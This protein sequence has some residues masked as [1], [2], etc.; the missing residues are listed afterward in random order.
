MLLRADA[1]RRCRKV[2]GEILVVAKD[3][4]NVSM[5]PSQPVQENQFK[6]LIKRDPQYSTVPWSVVQTTKLV[7]LI[8]QEQTTIENE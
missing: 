7:M 3:A 1:S 2:N 8:T 5:V 4:R 6:I